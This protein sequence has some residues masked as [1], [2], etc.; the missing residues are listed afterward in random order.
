MNTSLTARVVAAFA[1][2][3]LAFCALV[4]IL[5]HRVTVEHEQE[6]LQR[7]S[8]GLARHI[9][10]HWPEVARPAEAAVDRAALDKLLGMLM[11]VNPAIDV[12][13]LDELG[14]VRAY[15]GDAKAVRDPQ[16]DI[17][18]V[19]AFLGDADLPLRGSDPRAPGAPKIFSAAMFPSPP[20]SPGPPGYLYVVLNGEAHVRAEN[21][22]GSWRLW[23]PAALAASLGLGVT[24]IAGALTFRRITAPLRLLAER[25]TAFS[26]DESHAGPD[27]PQD[28]TPERNEVAAIE[29]AFEGMADR[30]ERQIRAQAE[31]QAAHRDV[32][33]N[34][35][36]DLR[37]P[38][39]ALHGYLETLQQHGGSLGP[40][41]EARY[42]AA[43]LAQSDKVRR[44]SQQLFELARLQSSSQVLQRDRFRLDELVQDTVQRFELSARPAPVALMGPPPGRIDMEGDLQLIDRALTNLIDNAIRHGAGSE[45][46]RV[47]VQHRGK[48][49]T[50]LIEDRGPG[51]PEELS[52]RLDAGQPVREPPRQVPGG[53]SGGLGLAIAQRIAWLHGGTLRTL[54]SAAGGTRLVLA[55]PLI[56]RTRLA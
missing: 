55:L 40:E 18:I 21:L 56:A 50:V 16:V 45:P 54:P 38:L 51:L 4:A 48:G 41:T 12:Y 25:M 28:T 23:K 3:L 53:G 11:T 19:R 33:A 44:L 32:I 35:A 13:V 2:L 5:E 43:A 20:G 42:L 34:V 31:Q 24:L 29:R 7:L 49:A 15:L 27:T 14:R 1:A 6:T 22:A 26:I 46:V 47:T 39:T 10:E 30:I 52:R 17:T 8:H 9:V 36:H 37:T